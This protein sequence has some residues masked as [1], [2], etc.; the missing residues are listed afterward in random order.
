M[1]GIADRL[2]FGPDAVMI[3]DQGAATSDPDPAQI[4]GD[5]DAP[6]D[7]D[8]MHRV[9][10]AVEAH[11]M[12]ARQP[13]RGSPPDAG[14][15]R[16]QCQHRC[17]IGLDAI[18]RSTSQHSV[19]AVIGPHQPGLQLGIEI[20]R[21]GKDPTRQERPLQVVVE[22]FDQPLGFGITG[23][24]I[25]TLAARVPRKAWHAA[26]SSGWRATTARPRPRRPTPTPLER[27]PTSKDAATTRHTSLR[28]CVSGSTAP[29][30]TANTHT[31]WSAQVTP[32]RCG[33]GRTPPAQ[34]HRGTRSRTAR[35]HRPHMSRDAGSGGRYS[36][37]NSR[38]RPLSVRIEYHQPIRSAI[39]VAGIRG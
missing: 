24:Q 27:R 9:V 15:D 30:P 5:L 26:V 33:P 31:P 16:R 28:R 12:I 7:R 11:V 23:L 29:R 38:T 18:C 14:P 6:A 17:G 4:C 22:T 2:V 37:R 20:R 1:L 10:V 35:S 21:R 34:R 8:R 19:L 39:T 36:G 3:G 13:C 32:W 25:H